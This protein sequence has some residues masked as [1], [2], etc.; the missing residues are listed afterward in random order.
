MKTIVSQPIGG[1]GATASL[2]VDGGNLN[3]Q[4]SYP[5]AKLVSPI[6]DVI[7]AAIN[8]VEAAIPGD[9]DKAILEPI[10]IA[11]KAELVSLLGLV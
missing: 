4:I 6:N 5:I 9:W 10:R 3:A 1:D 8:K 11:A 2:T 7:D